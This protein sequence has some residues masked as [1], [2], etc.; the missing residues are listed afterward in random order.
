MPLRV[1]LF[2]RRLLLAGGRCGV[3]G[4]LHGEARA[5]PGPARAPQ[6][7]KELKPESS[8]HGHL[9]VSR[10][11][12]APFILVVKEPKATVIAESSRHLGE[13]KASTAIIDKPIA[14]PFA[15]GEP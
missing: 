11:D 10:N 13:L 7:L 15:F 6:E 8:R 1:A 4:A 14:V 9:L 2:G 3:A 12:V 5:S